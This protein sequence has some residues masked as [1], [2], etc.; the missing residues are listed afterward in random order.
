MNVM[1]PFVYQFLSNEHLLRHNIRRPAH[2]PVWLEVKYSHKTKNRQLFW[3]GFMKLSSVV[4]FAVSC[5]WLVE[6]PNGNSI[7]WMCTLSHRAAMQ[8]PAGHLLLRACDSSHGTFGYGPHVACMP[9]SQSENSES[10]A[11]LNPN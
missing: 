9:F 6:M 7:K 8:S 10:I 3:A 5:I 2:N 11:R 1:L 4:T